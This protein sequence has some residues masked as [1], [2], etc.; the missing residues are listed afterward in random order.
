VNS[1]KPSGAGATELLRTASAGIFFLL[2][3]IKNIQQSK[4]NM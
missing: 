1:D 3:F 2:S 4:Y